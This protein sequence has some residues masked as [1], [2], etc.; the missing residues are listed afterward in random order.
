MLMRDEKF[1]QLMTVNGGLAAWRYCQ[2]ARKEDSLKRLGCEGKC[3]G[4]FFHPS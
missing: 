4:M 3:E 2:H 1:N